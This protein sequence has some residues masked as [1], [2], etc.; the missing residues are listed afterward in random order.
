[1]TSQFA[2]GLLG[3]ETGHYLGTSDHV[4]RTIA[5]NGIRLLV[6]GHEAIRPTRTVAR[7]GDST[8]PETRLTLAQR[9]AGAAAEPVEDNPLILA[10]RRT[11]GR[12]ILATAALGQAHPLLEAACRTPP[13]GYDAEAVREAFA[14][15]TGQAA[16]EASAAVGGKAVREASAAVGGKAVREAF[17]AVSGEAVRDATEV[18]RASTGRV[19]PSH[20]SNAA[21]K[22]AAETGNSALRLATAGSLARRLADLGK[23]GALLAPDDAIP[24]GLREALVRGIGQQRVSR[25]PAPSVPGPSPRAR[26]LASGR[27]PISAPRPTPSVEAMFL[28]RR[29]LPQLTRS[30]TSVEAMCALLEAMRGLLEEMTHHERASAEAVV[31]AEAR[32][33]EAEER[34]AAAFKLNRRNLRVTLGAVVLA[35]VCASPILANWVAFLWRYVS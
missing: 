15:V 1:V 30:A 33:V 5:A 12:S 8:D 20:L 2:Y 35:V 31:R 17:A 16:R 9:V 14:A 23:V 13:P 26:R 34:E 10:R 18:L 27:R 11:R 3:P 22:A 28:E 6:A 21:M 4:A 7:V 19:I 29:V 24:P 32:A 25:A